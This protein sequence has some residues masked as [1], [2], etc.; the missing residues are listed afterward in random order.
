[1]VQIFHENRPVEIDGRQLQVRPIISVSP[2]GFSP[3]WMGVEL[4]DDGIPTGV[5]V[6]VIE[7]ERAWITEQECP[8]EVV[9]ALPKR[10]F[11][12]LQHAVAESISGIQSQL[13]SRSREAQRN[14]H[15]VRSSG[16]N[17]DEAMKKHRMYEDHLRI[18]R[19][20][21]NRKEML[22]KRNR[23]RAD[24]QVG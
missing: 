9:D 11:R 18:I 5:F 12:H 14:A 6:A 2:H 16:G 24:D 17:F 21:R 10:D 22:D 15:R 1:M 3:F 19:L 7:G 23:R 20:A 13:I 8:I 4:S